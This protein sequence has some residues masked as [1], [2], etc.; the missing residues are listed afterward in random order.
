[1]LA[2]TAVAMTTHPVAPIM[3]SV[4][5]VENDLPLP[6]YKS[7]FGTWTLL[8]HEQDRDE[9]KEEEKRKQESSGRRSDPIN[10]LL[11][12]SSVEL[13]EQVMVDYDEEGEDSSKGRW[14][15]E[16]HK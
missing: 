7:I 6:S 3:T 10:R 8:E 4:G 14:T 5:F 1:M 16:E 9:L 13:L 2:T 11:S 15:A 12:S